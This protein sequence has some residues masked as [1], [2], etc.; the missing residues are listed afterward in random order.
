MERAQKQW[1]ST[2]TI[3]LDSQRHAVRLELEIQDGHARVCVLFDIGQ[4]FPRDRVQR[5]RDLGRDAMFCSRQN[6]VGFDTCSL[7]ELADQLPKCLDYAAIVDFGAI[8]GEVALTKQRYVPSFFR[9]SRP[10]QL[11]RLHLRSSRPHQLL[12]LHLR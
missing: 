5:F 1:R 3:V 2:D 4:A 11:L 9:S 6:E 12:R 8:Q 10:H 7:L